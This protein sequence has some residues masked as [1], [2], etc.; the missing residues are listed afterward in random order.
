MRLISDVLEMTK[1]LNID[2]FILTMDIEKAFDSVDHPFLFATLERFGFDSYFLDWIKVLLNKQESCVINGGVSTGYFPLERGS[3]QGDPI[4]AYLFIIVME[5]FFTM[6][7]NNPN[8]KGLDILGFVYL[9]TSYADDATFFPKDT[10]SV[11]EIFNTFNLFSKYSGLKAN[12]SKCEIAG[13][14]VKNGAQLALL[15]LKNID[16]NNDSIKILGYPSH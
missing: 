11:H 14:G 15:G 16:L 2:G 4:S 5:I 6:V 13:I 12:I 8:I 7:R 1:T 3:R 9:L 10:K